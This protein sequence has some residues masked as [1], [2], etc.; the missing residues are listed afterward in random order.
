MMTFTMAQAAH[1]SAL[2]ALGWA[3]SGNLKVPHATRRDGLRLWFKPQAVLASRGT[4]LGDA[5][6]LHC[7]PRADATHALV[8]WAE[9]FTTRPGADLDD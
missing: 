5:R 4:V 6:S 9:R 1:L 2:A 3:V 7:D 8:A